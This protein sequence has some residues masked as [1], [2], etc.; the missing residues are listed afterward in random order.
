MTLIDIIFRV[1]EICK[2]Y[3]KYDVNR[4]KDLDGAGKDAFSR[5]YES[6]ESDIEATLRKSEAAAMETNRAKVVAMTAETRKN[7]AR[8]LEEVNGLSKDDTVARGD[9]ALELGE[10]IRGIPDGST[11]DLKA[12][13]EKRNYVK[14]D[15]H[16]DGRLNEGFFHETGESNQFRQEYEMRKI[17]QDEGLDVISEGL[18]K[19]KDLAHEMNEELDRQVPLTDE[20]DTKVDKATSDLKKN[21]LRLKET[22]YQVRS[23]RNFCLDVILLCIILGIAAYLYK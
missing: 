22:L 3:E 10:R 2:K 1:D 9:L 11:A 14:F 15:M 12:A 20:M 23:S 17:K 13:S 16:G 6:I 4:H 21:N 7:K 18:D 8:L 19:L 5:L